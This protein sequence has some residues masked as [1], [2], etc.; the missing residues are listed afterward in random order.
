MR[1]LLLPY[2]EQD[3]SVLLTGSTYEERVWEDN[4][5]IRAQTT[6]LHFLVPNRTSVLS[7]LLYAR[8][9]RLTATVLFSVAGAQAFLPHTATFSCQHCSCTSS[10]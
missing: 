8:E 1:S 2:L 4:T 7:T 5:R 6:I 9:P 10:F 3:I